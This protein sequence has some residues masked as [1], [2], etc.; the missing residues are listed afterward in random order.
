MKI[1]HQRI[2]DRFIGIPLCWVFSLLGRWTRKKRAE[3][4][5][6]KI[7][8]ILL[9]E[10][11]SLVLAHPM[12][13]TLKRKYPDASIHVLLFEQNR[14]FLGV[15]ETV[16]D[17][18]ILTVRND[19]LLHFVTDS[20][21][22]LVRMRRLAIDT[23]LDCELFT[24]ISSLYSFLSGA[25]R[26]VGFHPHKQEGL[27]RGG[28]INRPV[29]YNPYHH[30]S[31]QFINLAEAI[32]SE[33]CPRVKRSVAHKLRI[34]RMNAESEEVET[35]RKRFLQDFPNLAGKRLVLVY[36]GGGL[37]PIRAWPLENYCRISRD[38]LDKGYGVGIIGLAGDKELARG[39]QAHCQ[40]TNCV[41]LTGYT[42]TVRDLML[43]FHFASLLITND[44]GPGHF[45]SMT[46]IPA[47]L[48]YGPECPV[49]YGPLGDNAYC[50]HASLS[51][52]PCL[53]AY[54]HRNTPCDGNNLCLKSIP[55][56]EVISKA[57]E[58]LEGR[59]LG[60]A[61]EN[62]RGLR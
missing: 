62:G 51:C 9:S 32:E 38:L 27:Y 35:A 5:P 20:L 57:H 22:V 30:I 3:G 25:R 50:F 14:E 13:E 23:V 10:M 21:K 2:M 24:R 43:I 61:S 7:L 8:I 46:P 4:P 17:S 19:S 11:G 16:P 37:L 31:Q 26:I 39:I 53:T 40:D 48:L 45:A 12:F 6:K 28:F 29:L 15:L 36:P 47:L 49:L 58:M 55:V 60:P 52:S 18:R 1:E 59:R 34:P 33:G 44:G 54:N 56:E 41:D 42:A